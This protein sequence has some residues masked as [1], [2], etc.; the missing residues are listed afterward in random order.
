M[1][2]VGF[3]QRPVDAEH[4]TQMWTDNTFPGKTPAQGKDL[5]PVQSTFNEWKSEIKN[6]C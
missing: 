4:F 3:N 5:I 6:L 2:S 1:I